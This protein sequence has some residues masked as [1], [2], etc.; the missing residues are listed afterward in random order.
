[1]DYTHIELFPT[2]LIILKVDED[3]DDLKSC[4]KYRF[5][6]QN[7]N[8]VQYLERKDGKRILEEY[9]K[10][11]DILL[12]KFKFI[13]RDYMQYRDKDYII[14][15]SRLTN[16]TSHTSSSTH[17][18]QNSFWSGVYYYQDDY[19]IK[20]APIT[21]HNPIQEITSFNYADDD[22]ETYNLKN[23]NTFSVKPES[24]TLL[25]FPSYLYHRVMY[26]IIDAE[27][28][29]LAFN[30]M[31]ITEWGGGDSYFNMDWVRRNNLDKVK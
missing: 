18:H 13:A 23:T 26:Q 27:R 2:P 10:I 15:T 22:I 1:M 12:D 4:D 20:T 16:T 5:N 14:T 17:K 30:I 8:N 21:F 31:P 3:T 7:V 29:S 28:L 9:P 6:S 25:L 19:P 24:K 11:R